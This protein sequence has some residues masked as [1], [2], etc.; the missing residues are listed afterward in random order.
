KS[1]VPRLTFILLTSFF[2]GYMQELELTLPVRLCQY[3]SMLIEYQASLVWVLLRTPTPRNGA[4]WK[5]KECR[6]LT[7]HHS[8]TFLLGGATRREMEVRLVKVVS[9]VGG[10]L[11]K[12][13]TTR[14]IILGIIG[15]LGAMIIMDLVMVIE[16]LIMRLPLYTYLELIGSVLGGGILLGVVLHILLSLILGL[17]F[18]TL[19]FKVDAFYI[20]T[21][22]KGFILG[23][24]AGAVTIVGCVPFAIITGVPIVEILGFSTIPHIV[25][26][27]VWGVVVGYGL[28]E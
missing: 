7:S 9:F 18:V 10:R 1:L 25:F 11:V 19:V 2:N 14:V 21:I 17:L 8:R 23:V 12:N 24:I 28:R 6:S 20:K 5:L 15:G 26:G 22:K 3:L 4:R 13:S 16:F 27:A